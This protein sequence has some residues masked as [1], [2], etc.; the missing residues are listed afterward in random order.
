MSPKRLLV[1]ALAGI[2]VQSLADPAVSTAQVKKW[3]LSLH[4]MT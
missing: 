4:G 1:V 3:K 2:L